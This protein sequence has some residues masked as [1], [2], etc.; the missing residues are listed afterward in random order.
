MFWREQERKGVNAKAPEPEGCTSALAMPEVTADGR[1]L[2]GQNWDWRP[3]AANHTMVLKIRSDDHP[4]ALHFVEA[5][6]LA[7][8][9]MN[10]AGIAVTAMG[11]HSG[12]DYGRIGIPSP[13]IR[14]RALQASD[15]G[16][17]LG[18]VFKNPAS[19]SHALILS[20]ADGE[21]FTLEATPGEVFWQEPENGFLV[22]ANHFKTPQALIKVR[23][24]NLAR[25][26]ESL[27]RDARVG[28]HL[29]SNS[30]RVSIE[31][32]KDAFADRFGAPNSVLRHPAK[33]PGGV[34]SA[35]VYTLIMCPELGT[36][37]ISL[38]PY[39]GAD[40]QRL[41]LD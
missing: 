39:D 29:G 8:H 30:G 40:F 5:G 34:M 37:D 13:V 25:C 2:H 33:R 17:A 23:D 18:E 16:S 21:A 1:L 38:R 7:R 27:Y 3:D 12:Q 20:D 19:F 24:A 32:F 4:D 10:K 26:P 41:T 11:L 9:G 31:T 35:T 14:R 36:A 15:F 6:Q 28:R 22:H